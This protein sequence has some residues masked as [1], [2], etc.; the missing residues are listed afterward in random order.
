MPLLFATAPYVVRDLTRHEL[1]AVQALFE[2]NPSYF[3]KAGG[4][5]PRPD[6]AERQFEE[7]PPPHLTFSERWFAGVFDDRG[8]LRG[9]LIV[10]SD[11]SAPGVWQIALFF[12]DDRARGTGIAIRLH[13]ALEAWAHARGAQWLR[14]AVISGNAAAERFWDKVGYTEVRTRPYVNA[15]GNQVTA[16]ILIRP[17]AGS[18]IEDYLRLVPRDAPDSALP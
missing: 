17:L 9:L 7:L 1:P 18:A 6:E 15:G 13:A 5:P 2:A 11:L 14:L 10:T 4:L 16:R 8:G 3:I 12:L